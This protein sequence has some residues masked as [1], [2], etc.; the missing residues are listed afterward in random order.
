ML[1]FLRNQR[2][3]L[4][5]LAVALTEVGLVIP[6]L[7]LFHRGVSRTGWEEGIPGA[8][9][10]LLTFGAA[11]L[12]EAGDR[13]GRATGGR[14]TG[15]MLAGAAAAYAVAYF[16][17]PPH[18]R[19]GLL[20]GNRAMVMI[21]V[22]CY[23]WYTATAAVVEGLD[24]SR[25][26][27]RLP[28]QALAVVGATVIL[29]LSGIDRAPQVGVLL[30]WSVILFFG[31]ALTA[32]L[33]ARQ[34]ALRVGQARLGITGPGGQQHASPAVATLVMGLL[35]L[36]LL[37]SSVLSTDRMAAIAGAAA[38]ALLAVFDW[39][40][41]LAWLIIYRWVYLIASLLEPLF[42]WLRVK[43]QDHKWEVILGEQGEAEE[44][45]IKQLVAESP[46]PWLETLF[47][48][49]LIAGVC[50]LF[51]WAALKLN[52]RLRERAPAE[53][54]EV[55]SLGFWANLM[56]D[57]KGLLA[58]PARPAEPSAAQAAPEMLDARDP[59]ALYRRLQAWGASLGRPRRESETP[60]AYQAVL[61]EA[62]PEQARAVGTV[63][64]VYHQARYGAQPPAA[65]DVDRAVRETDS[66]RFPPG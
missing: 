34:E 39:V 60:A 32:I 6:F 53:E 22:A 17:L 18:L 4:L 13:S 8:W 33:L 28:A 2:A 58:R 27:S 56:A 23:L 35:A 44:P 43:A 1:P 51:I 63:T 46:P 9:L 54:E 15:M 37:A 50:A 3:L 42:R 11:A 14:R 55:I 36:T 26:F 47:T 5:W 10:L 57:L 40:L 41:D 49:L 25:L 30:Y 24:Y 20:A 62:Q 64:A 16:G 12:W 48:V 21:P 19:E 31:A 45:L 7:I 29:V 61:S 59:R 66:L 52:S 65:Q 38:G